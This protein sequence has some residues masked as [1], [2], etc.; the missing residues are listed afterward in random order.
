MKLTQTSDFTLK[1]P[2]YDVF[3]TKTMVVALCFFLKYDFL[4]RF[5]EYKFWE[6]YQ[7]ANLVLVKK[8]HKK[9]DYRVKS[10]LNLFLDKSHCNRVKL[11]GDAWYTDGW[12]EEGCLQEGWSTECCIV[13][14]N[15]VFADFWEKMWNFCIEKFSDF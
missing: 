1:Y 7:V 15:T 9:R 12:S 14:K 3:S 10:M 5:R 2:W 4:N 11:N 6:I 8:K 13:E